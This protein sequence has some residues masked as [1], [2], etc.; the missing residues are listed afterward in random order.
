MVRPWPNQINATALP[1]SSTTVIIARN[2]GTLRTGSSVCSCVPTYNDA[3]LHLI[4]VAC[5]ALYLV[6]DSCTK[7]LAAM[8]KLPRSQMPSM[9]VGKGLRIK[10]QTCAF[11]TRQTVNEVGEWLALNLQRLLPLQIVEKLPLNVVL[12]HLV[13]AM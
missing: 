12:A 9:F 4:V 11:Y 1:N 3:Y 7:Q 10:S 2:S 6:V 8:T 5:S 13:A